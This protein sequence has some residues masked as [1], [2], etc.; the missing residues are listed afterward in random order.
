MHYGSYAEKE[1]IPHPRSKKDWKGNSSPR[2][3]PRKM[4][5]LDVVLD[6]AI[7][8]ARGAGVGG[9]LSRKCDSNDNG[10]CMAILAHI[11]G[12]E[13]KVLS[14]AVWDVRNS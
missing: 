13:H 1:D 9:S 5:P 10:I 4:L 11:I 14:D 8:M 7:E 2:I 6:T 12:K 3:S